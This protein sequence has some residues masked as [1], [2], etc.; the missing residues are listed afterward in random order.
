MTLARNRNQVACRPHAVLCGLVPGGH[1]KEIYTAQAAS[2]LEPANPSDAVA[3]ARAELLA[4]LRHPGAQLW[5]IKKKL[6]AAV[7]ASRTTLTDVFGV[8]PIAARTIIGAPVS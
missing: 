6:A 1:P 8:G 5:E 3:L 2:I 4:D 7:R